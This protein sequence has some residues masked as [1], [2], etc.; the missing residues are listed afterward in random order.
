MLV[1]P[2]QCGKTTLAREIFGMKEGSYFDLEDPETPLRPEIAQLVLKDLRGLVVIDE[3]QRQP[4]LLPLLRVLA[5]R[6]PLPARFL[7]LGSASLDIVKG[8]SESLAGR[9]AY[10][11]MGGFLLN[12][13]KQDDSHKLW[14]RGSF[15]LSFLARNDSISYEWRSYFIQS[16]L[17]RDIPQLGIRIPASAL[18]RFWVMLA[19]YHG[20]VWNASDLARS[21]GTKEDTARKYLDILTGTFLVRQLPPWFENIGKRL[22]KAAKVY[23]RDSGLLHT[24]L[25]LKDR[26][27]V[28]SHPKLGFSWEGFAIEQVLGMT[29]AERDAYFYKTHGGAELDC[30]I[31]RGGKKYGFKFKFTDAPSLIKSMHIVCDDLKL[32]QLFIIYPGTK[33][34]PMAEKVEAAPLLKLKQVLE[35]HRLLKEG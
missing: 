28:L 11:Q 9:A 16:F 7:I 30:L 17:E 14:V 8:V 10:I 19:H 18:R 29:G 6:K 31:V 1:G 32:E 2:R 23:I 27:H 21:I 22:V 24:L 15:P 34:Y 20:Q 4:N 12:E 3:F 26:N 5:D 25:G 33:A 13:I 35:K